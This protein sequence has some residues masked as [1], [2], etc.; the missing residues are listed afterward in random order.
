MVV[1][2]IAM[3]AQRFQN[4]LQL[5]TES[6]GQCRRFWRPYRPS[7]LFPRCQDPHSGAF[8]LLPEAKKLGGKSGVMAENIPRINSGPRCS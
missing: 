7:S 4:L 6:G 3:L 1:V 8:P 2:S 5:P